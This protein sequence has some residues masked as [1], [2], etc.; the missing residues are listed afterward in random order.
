MQ[1]RR[2][3]H[4]SESTPEKK[5]GYYEDDEV[6]FTSSD[7]FEDIRYVTGELGCLFYRVDTLT[8]DASVA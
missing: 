2:T 5:C 6:Y 8:L 3:R 4:S 1:N 7:S